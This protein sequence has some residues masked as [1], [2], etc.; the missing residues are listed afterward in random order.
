[1]DLLSLHIVKH[2]FFKSTQVTKKEEVDK[3]KD[4]LDEKANLKNQLA[5]MKRECNDLKSQSQEMDRLSIIESRVKK[6]KRRTLSLLEEEEEPVEEDEQQQQNQAAQEVVVVAHAA[7]QGENTNEKSS[8]SSQ[9]IESST[10]S[11]VGA[12]PNVLPETEDHIEEDIIPESSRYVWHIT[13]SKN[14]GKKVLFFYYL[15]FF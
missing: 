13:N 6:L 14:L 1:M 3:F 5:A 10:A 11:A 15:Y 2:L 4:I 7:I 9:N 12:K 8:S